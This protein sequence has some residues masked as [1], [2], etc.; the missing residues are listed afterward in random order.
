M[1][2]PT[3]SA[4]V[5]LKSQGRDTGISSDFDIATTH[6]EDTNLCGHFVCGPGLDHMGEVR[7]AGGSAR[8]VESRCTRPGKKALC[9]PTARRRLDKE[10]SGQFGHEERSV[11]E[12]FYVEQ[13]ALRE[14]MSY[15]T[16]SLLVSTGHIFVKS[17]SGY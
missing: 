5:N 11:V 13:R 1:S 9:L 16:R 12:I 7:A 4:G 3:G 10:R 2:R 14:D 17:F 6:G 8:E 15:R